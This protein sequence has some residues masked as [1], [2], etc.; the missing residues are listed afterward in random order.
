MEALADAWLGTLQ[1]TAQL[2]QSMAAEE[3]ARATDLPGWSVKDN[4]SHITGLEATLLGWPQPEH[5]LP[6]GLAHVHGDVGRFMEVAV[7]TRRSWPMQKITDELQQ[8]IATHRASFAAGLPAAD[9]M[10]PGPFGRTRPAQNAF[11]MRAFD[12]WAHEQDIR[13]A[14]DR[15]GNLD[16]GAAM[17]SYARIASAFGTVLASAGLDAGTSVAINV[18]SPITLSLY[19]YVDA[20]GIGHDVTAIRDPALVLTMDT[21]AWIR[22]S[23]GRVD[24]AQSGAR[25]I[26]DPAAAARL[27]GAMAITP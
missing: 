16:S 19:G 6:E 27:L 8:V 25:S 24:P 18:S 11:T 14:I 22:L 4:I 3:L 23:G 20:E 17:V 12:C 2:A 1:A 5:E 9:D 7:D 21:V 13:R 10:V 15:P 26:G